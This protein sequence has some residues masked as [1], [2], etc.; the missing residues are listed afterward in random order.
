M[1]R[2]TQNTEFNYYKNDSI[3]VLFNHPGNFYPLRA[4]QNILLEM[5][6]QGI[7]R[8]LIWIR[9]NSYGNNVLRSSTRLS[10][11]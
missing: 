6:H 4:K 10:S 8:L 9:F 1:P 3:S 7:R 2:N 5:Q 11:N